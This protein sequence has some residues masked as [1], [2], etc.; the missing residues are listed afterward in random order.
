MPARRD[1]DVLDIPQVMSCAV[2][3]EV[4]EPLDYRY[5]LVGTIVRENTHE[6]YTGR[7]LSE[8]PGKGPDSF[9]WS[10]LERTRLDKEPTFV[11][12]PYVGPK[13]G[14]LRSTL[15]MLPLA[16]DGVTVNQIL[17]SVAFHKA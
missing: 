14:I 2:L 10:R 12:V 15:L 7:K 8:L 16:D 3:F 5:R 17:L 9:L 11:E 4:L 6:D 13:K 1:L